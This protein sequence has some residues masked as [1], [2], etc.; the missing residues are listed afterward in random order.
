MLFRTRPLIFIAA[1]SIGCVAFG[2]DEVRVTIPNSLDLTQAAILVSETTGIRIQY[3]AARM[4]GSL[5]VTDGTNLTPEEVWSVF[6]RSLTMAGLA[7]IMT[8]DPGFMQVVA[9]NDAG[10][11]SKN[12][13]FAELEA[14]RFP[15]SVCATTI[16]TKYV[17]A[18][19]IQKATSAN[20]QV[21]NGLQIR[22]LGGEL[23]QASGTLAA[24]RQIRETVTLLDVPENVPVVRFILPERSNPGSLAASALQ[25]WNSVNRMR[26]SERLADI[27]VAPDGRRLV[28]MAPENTIDALTAFVQDLD[29]SEPNEQR[30]YRPQFF[31]LDDVARLLEQLVNPSDGAG[32][33]ISIVS[34]RLTGSLVIA[35]TTAQHARI[36]SVLAGL[37][38]SPADSRRQSR[39]FQVRHRNATEVARTLSSLLDAG[40]TSSGSSGSSN[41]TTADTS[42]PFKPTNPSTSPTGLSPVNQGD[43]G[44][45]APTNNGSAT[46]AS[47]TSR[48]KDGGLIIAA[49]DVTNRLI[50]LGEPR[51]LDEV[52][53]LL[54]DLD[55]RQPQVQLE[56]I[57]VSL[58]DTK[59][60]E[61]GIELIGRI[62]RNEISATVTSLFG[63]SAIPANNP[64]APTVGS[65]AGMTGVLINP[66]DYAGVVR[67]LETL[68]IGNSLIR[69]TVV[70]NQNAKAEV[71]GVVQE[72]ITA[73]NSSQQVATTSFAGTSDAGTQLSLQP[74][75]S[76]GDYITLTYAITQSSFLGTTTVTNDGAVIP[77]TRRADSVSSIAT[78]PDGFVIALGGL[79]NRSDK[80]GESRIPFLGT[81]PILGHLFKQQSKGRSDSRFYVFIKANILR[82]QNFTDLRLLSGLEQ[83]QVDQSALKGPIL[84]P[85]RMR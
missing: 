59:N 13:P 8:D 23:I 50:C 85:E 29:R 42:T 74:Q 40:V 18:D 83:K 14:L 69:S 3:D 53:R 60:R 62:S 56:I 19:Q 25:G 38:Q 36:A 79:S 34:D 66:G 64:T 82:H 17:P 77:P 27:Q 44:I 71:Q 21:T 51:L 48:T 45:N 76:P 55:Q 65:P 61:L 58:S 84:Q 70:V 46:P 49:D 73:I 1:L 35:A 31:A 7:T 47:S 57:L 37:D 26:G 43:N 52:A 72:P 24:L 22:V 4:G 54:V 15:P 33:R 39:S 32:G 11:L 6:N 20:G 63:L 28:V 5:N 41:S 12:I 75:I 68:S 10:G 30:T 67:A 16:T 2:A 78:I 80:N 9:L 81:I